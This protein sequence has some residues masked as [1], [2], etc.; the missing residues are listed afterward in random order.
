MISNSFNQTNMDFYCDICD[1]TIKVKS[2][3]NHFK[4]VSQIQNKKWF[5]INHTVKNPNFVDIDKI[6][7]DYVTNHNKNFELFFV[8]VDFKL[9]FDNFSPN[10]SNIF[11]L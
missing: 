1:K 3:N 8:R 10:L 9:D 6:F 5:R 2:K 7:N 4:S 11:S